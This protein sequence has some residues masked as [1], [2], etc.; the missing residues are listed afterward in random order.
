MTAPIKRK[1]TMRPED[2]FRAADNR[3]K[4]VETILEQMLAEA[5]ADFAAN[6]MAGASLRPVSVGP[7]GDRDGA[8]TLDVAARKPDI[9][10][11]CAIQRELKLDKDQRER[12]HKIIR[13]GHYPNTYQGIR[14]AAI[15]EFRP[16]MNEDK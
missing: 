2:V 9:Q 15:D 10:M 11:I 1:S 3:L 13:E 7:V 12:L 4:L 5:T 16:W 6:G 14:Q 8:A